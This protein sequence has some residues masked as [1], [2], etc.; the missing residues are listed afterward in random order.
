MVSHLPLRS[1]LKTLLPSTRQEVGGLLLRP[2]I[3]VFLWN[4]T[5]APLKLAPYINEV[6]VVGALQ[7]Q[8]WDGWAVSQGLTLKNEQYYRSIYIYS[9]VQALASLKWM[10]FSIILLA[11]LGELTQPFDG[12]KAYICQTKM[13]PTLLRS[14]IEH[15]AHNITWNVSWVMNFQGLFT[16]NFLAIR[17]KERSASRFMFYTTLHN[18]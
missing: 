8:R 6:C 4:C 16:G 5:Y 12:I 18:F 2:E 1:S 15:A 14:P 3:F 13:N 11:S 17:E 9:A 10:E 7:D